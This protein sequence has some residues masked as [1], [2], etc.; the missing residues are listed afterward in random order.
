MS[1]A[2]MLVPAN[3][4][5]VQ[6]PEGY[7]LV[8]QVRPTPNNASNSM[9][10]P[11]F[12]KNWSRNQRKRERKEQLAAGG[13]MEPARNP[14]SVPPP[15]T[16][17]TGIKPVVAQPMGSITAEAG[18]SSNTCTGTENGKVDSESTANHPGYQTGDY[19]QYRADKLA[20]R[21]RDNLS[22]EVMLNHVKKLVNYIYGF[23]KVLAS[24]DP[25]AEFE[26]V[27]MWRYASNGTTVITG[28]NI[29]SVACEILFF[30]K[31]Y[32]NPVEGDAFLTPVLDCMKLHPSMIKGEY[33]KGW[34]EEK[35]LQL[36]PDMIVAKLDS[37]T[38]SETWALLKKFLNVLDNSGQLTARLPQSI[39][40][41]CYKF[42]GRNDE[43]RWLNDAYNLGTSTRFNKALNTLVKHV[44]SAHVPLLGVNQVNILLKGTGISLN[45]F[46]GF[47]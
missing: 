39:Y 28:G 47:A 2:K 6:V 17:G 3:L 43:P 44:Q 20:V 14:G 37:V 41:P 11:T 33:L 5:G 38:R 31:T 35:I 30:F 24:P 27:R 32:G 40:Q 42:V 22:A 34:V 12:G 10:P 26:V 7:M 29:I 45:R 46:T 13:T 21:N 9:P 18:L 15:A 1:K 19:A 16:A 25:G 4:P 23:A 8:Q 36:H